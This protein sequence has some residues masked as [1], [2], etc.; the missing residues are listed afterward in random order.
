M[1]LV[2]TFEELLSWKKARELNKFIYTETLKPTF[3][4]DFAL[5]DQIRRSSTS[6]MSNIAEGFERGYLILFFNRV[7]ACDLFL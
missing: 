3:A 1:P 4:K 7:S 6:I 5:K 2:K